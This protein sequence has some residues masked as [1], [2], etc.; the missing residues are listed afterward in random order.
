[1]FRNPTRREQAARIEPVNMPSEAPSSWKTPAT[2]CYLRATRKKNVTYQ[3]RSHES[4]TRKRACMQKKHRVPILASLEAPPSLEALPSE[5]AHRLKKKSAILR[6]RWTSEA[7]S[8]STSTSSAS[9]RGS[10]FAPKDK[11][12]LRPFTRRWRCGRTPADGPSGGEPFVS[13]VVQG[14]DAHGTHTRG[15]VR[16]MHSFLPRSS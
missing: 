3:R 6:L 9:P 10:A 7:S 14:N 12:F 4:E 5:E 1:M 13:F 15:L 2:A 11:P 16:S 8:R